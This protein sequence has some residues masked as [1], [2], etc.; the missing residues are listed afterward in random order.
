MMRTKAD[1]RNLRQKHKKMEH[2]RIDKKTRA[3]KKLEK[4]KGFY[5]HLTAYLMVNV[6]ISVTII[7]AK[8][9]GGETFGEALWSIE[10]CCVWFFW[11]IGLVSHAIKV[12][13]YNPFFSKKWEERQIQKFMEEDQKEADNFRQM[14]NSYGK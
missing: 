7:L 5:K 14:G 8:I 9:N 2:N 3:K 11:G 6:F 12:F 1:E 10:T 13:T 4:L